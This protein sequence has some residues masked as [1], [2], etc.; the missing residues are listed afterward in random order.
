MAPWPR[1]RHSRAQY[2]GIEA[3]EEQSAHRELIGTELGVRG[4]FE[5]GVDDGGCGWRE[6][7]RAGEVESDP[8]ETKTRN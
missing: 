3:R 1:I 4:G 6:K 8:N 5:G 2:D 7:G